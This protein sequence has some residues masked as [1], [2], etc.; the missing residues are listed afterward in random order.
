M[1]RNSTSEDSLPL[2]LLIQVGPH[3]T[4]TTAIQKV[5]FQNSEKLPRFGVLY[6]PSPHSSGAHHHIPALLQGLDLTFLNISDPSIT[7]SSECDMWMKQVQQVYCSSLL[8]SSEEFFSL[9]VNQWITF[10]HLLLETAANNNVSLSNIAIW[11]TQ[12]DPESRARN[13]FIESIK[14]GN[15][16][17]FDR[18]QPSFEVRHQINDAV[19]YSLP[20]ELSIP[21]EVHLLPY[22]VTNEKRTLSFVGGCSK[23]LV[24]ISKIPFHALLFN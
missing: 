13:A 19:I 16:L 14:H 3:K 2:S 4:A 9:T 24:V 23:S 22:H 12:R 11:F 7:L 18:V 20:L 8:I 17:E 5:L 1:E 6:P 10:S 15:S 21:T